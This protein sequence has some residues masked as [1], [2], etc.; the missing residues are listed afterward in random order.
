LFVE[1]AVQFAVFGG[2]FDVFHS[3]VGAFGARLLAEAELH[4]GGL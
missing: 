3:A 2:G 1:F 4:L